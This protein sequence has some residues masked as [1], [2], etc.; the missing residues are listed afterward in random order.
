[1]RNKKKYL[2]V[3]TYFNKS[4]SKLFQRT[5]PGCVILYSNILLNCSCNFCKKMQNS[6][7]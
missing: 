7:I 5:I 1:M 4:P 2:N 3:K 6:L